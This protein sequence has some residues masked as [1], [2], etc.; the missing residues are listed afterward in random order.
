MIVRDCEKKK[1]TVDIIGMSYCI[2]SMRIVFDEKYKTFRLYAG[3]SLYAFSISPELCLEHLYWGET[4]QSGFDLRYLSES[5]RQTVFATAEVYEAKAE[6]HT[7]SLE[8][9]TIDEMLLLWKKNRALASSVVPLSARKGEHDE[10]NVFQQ[11][12]MENLSWR[13]MNMSSAASS[14]TP[15]Q[16]PIGSPTAR[17]MRPSPTKIVYTYADKEGGRD[18]VGVGVGVVTP[19][20]IAEA[21]RGVPSTET[22]K[23]QQQRGGPS[24]PLPPPRPASPSTVPFSH[25]PGGGSGSGDSSPGSIKSPSVSFLPPE[26][27]RHDPPP[28]LY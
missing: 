10:M 6:A 14:T 19:S 8:P 22:Q 11:R 20:A 7:I 23:L 21:F 13:M 5:A 15:L 28:A 12:R 16:S 25:R 17:A 26:G 4:L 3:K 2:P 1:R 9:D 18:Q 27:W 24:S